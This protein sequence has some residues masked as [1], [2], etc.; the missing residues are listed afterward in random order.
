MP[1]GPSG[2]APGSSQAFRRG[3]TSR[4][5]QTGDPMSERSDFLDPDLVAAFRRDGFVRVE[6]LVDPAEI[7][8]FRVHIDRAVAWRARNG[9][10]PGDVTFIDVFTSPGQ[11]HDFE[12]RQTERPIFVSA[13]PG[14]VLFHHGAT[15]HCAKPNRSDR[16]RRVHTAIYFRDG[17]TR[18]NDRPHHSL[19]RDAIAVGAPID[20][21]ATP[22]A[23]SL[24]G[25]R[26]PAPIPFPAVETHRALGRATEIGVFPRR[27]P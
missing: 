10:R 15:I 7:A 23:H 5:I 19:D 8:A 16:V 9:T 12:R 3:T 4:M 2:D 1:G 11:G 17:C 14:D 27:A 18:K 26:L 25:G 13:R 22:I 21:A 6:G 20:G 24:P